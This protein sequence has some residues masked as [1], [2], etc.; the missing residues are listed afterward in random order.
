[1]PIPSCCAIAGV[2]P[3]IVGA[4]AAITL[5][6]VVRGASGFGQA[7]V[8]VPRAGLLY[9]PAVAVPMLWVVDAFATPLLLRP[10]L[11]NTD[12]REVLLL[13]LGGAAALPAGVWLLTQA[14]PVVMRWVIC[15]L[16]L[17]CT[18][19]FAAGWSVQVPETAP[20]GLLLGGLSG[21]AGGATGMSGPPLILSWLGR[22]AAAARIRSNIFV[23]LWLLGF[24]SL[25][26]GAANGLLTYTRLLQGLALA[27]CYA[28][29]MFAG[30]LLF[31]RSGRMSLQR[32]ERLFRRAALGLCAASACAGLPLWH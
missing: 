3:R 23:Y 31:H 10:H 29:A 13:V 17:L 12:W 2:D 18:L 6:G 21:L 16:V 11:R 8:F 24:V 4:M 28:G 15:T 20:Y 26:A 32:R 27:P 1:M 5:A 14:D 9:R 19:A 7:L 22:R 25:G 30:S